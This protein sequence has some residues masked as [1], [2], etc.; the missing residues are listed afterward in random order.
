MWGG[1]VGDVGSVNFGE[2]CKGVRTARGFA[3]DV[4]DG[5]AASGECVGH[6]RAVAAPGDSFGAHKGAR[7]FGSERDGTVERGREFFGLHV[8]GIATEAGVAPGGVDGVFF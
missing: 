1:G 4:F 3:K 2:G 5:N 8:V 6:E 7:L